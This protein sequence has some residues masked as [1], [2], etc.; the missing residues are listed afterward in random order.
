MLYYWQLDDYIY[1]GNMAIHNIHILYTDI[2]RYL[3]G[4]FGIVVFIT[5][6]KWI[7]KSK[8]L[9][10]AGRYSLGIYILSTFPLHVIHY[11]NLKYD[12]IFF[13][14]LYAPLLSVVIIIMCIG[15][16]MLIGKNKTL[17]KYLFGG[18]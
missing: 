17:S 2:Y 8:P 10:L 9:E 12:I 4:F 1:V 15:I 5:I 11:L 13:N 3:I 16:N 14:F 7:P 18:R 6:I